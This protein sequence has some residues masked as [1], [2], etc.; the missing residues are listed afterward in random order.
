M[1]VSKYLFLLVTIVFSLKTSAQ[2]SSIQENMN[3]SN[4][5]TSTESEVFFFDNESDIC[6]IDF[7][8]FN[9][10]INSVTVK[11]ANGQEVFSEEVWDLPVNTIYE[12]STRDFKSGT[13][14]LILNT[15][16]GNMSK[17][18]EIR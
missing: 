12:L 13:Y 8:N 17:D 1:N 14:H 11:D 15:Y 5:T 4:F 7:A 9:V 3:I 2:S 6:F 18:I 16:K 10:N